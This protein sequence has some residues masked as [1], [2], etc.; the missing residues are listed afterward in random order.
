MPLT[1]SSPAAEASRTVAKVSVPALVAVGLLALAARALS[2][3]TFSLWV[4]E[5]L[6]MLRSRG[7]LAEAWASSRVD[8]YNPPL[9]NLLAWLLRQFGLDS[10]GQRL[11]M[12]AV[13]VGTVLLL[14]TW[15]GRRFG[16]RA[17]LVA[18]ITA[19]LA[20]VHVRY[21]QEL[22]P[23][24]LVV[25]FVVLSA[26]AVDRLIE[27]PSLA[28]SLLLGASLA[29]GLYSSYVFVLA[30]A[31]LAAICMDSALAARRAGGAAWR[32]AALGVGGAVVAAFV[33][34]LPWLVSAQRALGAAPLAHTRWNWPLAAS[35]WQF[36]TVGASEGQP[37]S[38]GGALA[39]I[40]FGGGAVL[41]RSDR[42]GRAA[43]VGAIVGAG[44]PILVMMWH[45]HWESGRY[46]LVGWPFIVI[47]IS[48][49]IAGLWSRAGN[50][51]GT[52]VLVLWGATLL[53]GLHSFDEHR[54][55]HWD[56]VAAAVRWLHHP[57]Q[58]ILAENGWVRLCL[59]YYLY[60][61][62]FD[63]VPPAD[64][65]PIDVQ[66]DPAAVLHQWPSG[67]SVLLV[68]GGFPTSESFVREAGRFELVA[69][70]PGSDDARIFVLAPEVLAELTK[71]SLPAGTWP[72]AC[73]PQLHVLPAELSREEGGGLARLIHRS[74]R[75]EPIA[76][77]DS[78]A[79][80]F[81]FDR[82]TTSN[83]LVY[84]WSGF[85]RG[86]GGAPFVWAE[87]RRAVQALDSVPHAPRRVTM[88]LSPASVVGRTQAV[89]VCLSGTSLGAIALHAGPQ[90]ITFDVPPDAWRTTGNWLEFH[91]AYDVAPSDVD[92]GN[93]DHRRLAAA[94]ERLD[95]E[96]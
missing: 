90:T 38:W 9:A 39:I 30:L 72:P 44:A 59:G 84:G 51:A 56:R 43:L 74:Q 26:A 83:A 15:V 16:R 20:P 8:F 5:I 1:S 31:P 33:A 29:F 48:L 94:F 36:L 6:V 85:E 96:L 82:A 55:P 41:A 86:A 58:R 49:G 21:S 93:G 79:L 45:P 23:Y 73:S 67:D 92:P 80:R 47:L 46:H 4:D 78:A 25:F 37:L 68:T 24:A 87:G 54:G 63:E 81:E 95:L 19:A 71:P 14:T 75:H 22:R 3:G 65:G 60:G 50:V 32:R 13:G 28:R 2:L 7:S 53:A 18:G 35:L 89:E 66:S 57:G 12:V 11:F 64:G 34:F 10:T 77:A 27:R 40:L 76:I 62:H 61:S 69:Q 42:W 88:R 17:G 52:A 70:F 91:F